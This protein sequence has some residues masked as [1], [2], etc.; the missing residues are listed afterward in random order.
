MKISPVVLAL[1][2]VTV[3]AR[4]EDFYIEEEHLSSPPSYVAAALAAENLDDGADN[5]CAFIG[6]F[7]DLDGDGSSTDYIATT[8]H[9]CGWGA[10][11]G[12]I[13]VLL[14]SKMSCAPAL[15]SLGYGLALHQG[16]GKKLRNITVT[17]GTAGHYEESLWEYNGSRYVRKSRYSGPPR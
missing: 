8:D 2:I 5:K 11:A 17:S 16:K 6:K 7:V 1:L 15:S 4:A 14:C 3:E 12:P 9:A 13:V 10:S